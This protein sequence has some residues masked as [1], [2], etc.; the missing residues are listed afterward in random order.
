MKVFNED[1]GG[2]TGYS[3]ILLLDKKEAKTL[4]EIVE[5]ACQA[6]KRKTTFKNWKKKLE[7][8]LCCYG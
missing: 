7:E 2:K 1:L 6:N 4:M 3:F 5:T 8:R